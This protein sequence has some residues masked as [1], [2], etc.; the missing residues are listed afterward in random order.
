VKP[1]LTDPGTDIHVWV[2]GASIWSPKFSERELKLVEFVLVIPMASN[3]DLSSS[4]NAGQGIIVDATSLLS[5]AV[6]Y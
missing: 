5:T 2:T 6:L 4:A 3:S 1:R